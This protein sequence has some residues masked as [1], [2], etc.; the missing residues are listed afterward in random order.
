MDLSAS[1]PG[2]VGPLVDVTHML[3]EVLPTPSFQPVYRGREALFLH[4][5]CMEPRWYAATDI[6]PTPWW[7]EVCRTR[8][9]RWRQ[10]HIK[11]SLEV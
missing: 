1:I 8:T 5:T 4:L 10:L 2:M 7:C 3:G 11:G 9:D 6:D